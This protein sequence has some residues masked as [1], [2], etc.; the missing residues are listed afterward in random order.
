MLTLPGQRMEFVEFFEN[1]SQTIRDDPKLYGAIAG[2][3]LGWAT[4]VLLAF[5]ITIYVKRKKK[6][7][8]DMQL[9]KQYSLMAERV[10]ETY[11]V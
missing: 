2:G 5:G 4:L 11:P 6:I 3:Y 10:H 8:K 9:A 7:Q 1:L